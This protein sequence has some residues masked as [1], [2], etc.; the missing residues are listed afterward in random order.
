MPAHK[1]ERTKVFVSYSRHDKDWLERLRVHLKPLQRELEI[2]IWDDSKI[3]P[4]E[5]WKDEIAKA[6]DSTKVAVLLISANFMAS[7]FIATGELPRLLNAARDDGAILVP[8]ILSSSRFGKTT[9]A[10]FETINDPKEPLVNMAFGRQEEVLNQLAEFIENAFTLS[11][12]TTTPATKPV[13]AIPASPE[14]KQT[15]SLK[16]S[17]ELKALLGELKLELEATLWDRGQVETAI[18]IGEV[19][20]M[21]GIRAIAM[22]AHPKRLE[23]NLINAVE[24]VLSRITES[25]KPLNEKD[26]SKFLEVHSRN[27]EIAELFSRAISEVGSPDGPIVI[28]P[29]RLT[30]IEIVQGMKFDHRR[31]FAPEFINDRENRRVVLKSPKILITEKRIRFARE[32]SS[33]GLLTASDDNEVVLIAGDFE[34]EALAALIADPNQRTIP[35]KAPGYGDRRREMLKDIAV[36]TGGTV[37]SSDDSRELEDV[38][39]SELG[40]ARKIIVDEENTTIVDWDVASEAVQY[41]IHEIKLDIEHTSSDYD[42]EKFQ[43]RLANLAGGVAIIRAGGNTEQERHQRMQ[44]FESLLRLYY[45][46]IRDEVVPGEHLSLINAA[47]H[48]R[49]LTNSNEEQLATSTLVY[50]LE[51]PFHRMVEGLGR[52]SLETLRSL[53]STQEKQKNQNVGY[54]G[55]EDSF[56]DLVEAGVVVPT[57]TVVEPVRAAVRFAAEKLGSLRYTDQLVRQFSSR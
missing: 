16:D 27:K 1:S 47:T 31:S 32:V 39:V 55:D 10:Y 12:E 24:G 28:E 19:V 6:I 46:A 40:S 25:K 48:L 54:Y 21:L 45:L 42:R 3:E 18:Q 15:R 9:I 36:L 8:L 30:E 17:P 26:V 29:G 57:G 4:G 50:A 7:D 37:I 38:D 11:D 44:L 34:E 13:S 14:H 52:S 41:R 56:V 35:V 5:K 43:E 53:H 23:R 49:E 51:D 2:D 20:L 33:L 22:R